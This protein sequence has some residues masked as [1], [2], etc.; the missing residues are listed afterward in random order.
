MPPKGQ[1][2]ASKK[3]EEKRRQ[4]L[5]EDKTFG[6]KNKKGAKMQKYCAMIEKNI[7]SNN[8]KGKQGQGSTS[9]KKEEADDLKDLTKIFKPVQTM[10]KI[11]ADVDPKS[12][13][14]VFF[15]QGLCA[16]G[17]KCKFSHDLAA[18]QK[19]AKRNIY[20]D[21][22][23]LKDEENAETNEHWDEATLNDVV[24]KKHGE[25][26][27]KRPNQTDIVCK[28]FLDAVEDSKY[29]WFWECP[30]GGTC[31]YRHALPKGYILKKDRK[32]LE[33]QSRLDQISLEELIENER[34]K[35]V[36]DSTTKVT[37]ETFLQWKKRK[38]HE[39]HNQKVVAER[40][41][42][43]TYKSGK[44]QGLSGRDL[45]TFNPDLVIDDN[46][47][48]GDIAQRVDDQDT[49]EDELKAFE[50]NEDTFCTLDLEG[51]RLLD[52]GQNDDKIYNADGNEIAEARNIEGQIM[53]DANLFDNVD[54]L[55]DD[56]DLSSSSEEEEEEE[57]E[58]ETEKTAQI[59][60]E[61]NTNLSQEVAEK[62]RC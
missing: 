30:N 11:G 62:L 6:L 2:Q 14:C 34:A 51:R 27:R 29:G 54:D 5:V 37:L 47:E 59:Q 23:D 7:L 39:K 42:M 46:T 35:L 57:F 36:T 20:V 22:R 43:K 45:F 55:P 17:N 50:I 58:P 3:A 25:N 31:I 44:Q 38:L 53:F 24:E 19:T 61:S 1:A 49:N 40:N 41:K 21:S 60:N 8:Q 12:V 32:K 4:K 15:K 52:F 28:Y 26:D 13:L 16:K 48:E 56:S 10:P 9:K 33:E 18:Q